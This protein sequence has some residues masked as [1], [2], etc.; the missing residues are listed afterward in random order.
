MEE[1]ISS[2]EAAKLIGIKTQTLAKWRWQG[3]GPEGWVQ[4]STTHVMYQ[5]REVEEFIARWRPQ[6]ASPEGGAGM[7]QLPGFHTTRARS[8]QCSTGTFR[9]CVGACGASERL[10]T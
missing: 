4:V 9:V 2:A 10:R 7:K 1:R 3:R 6:A 8:A 5:L